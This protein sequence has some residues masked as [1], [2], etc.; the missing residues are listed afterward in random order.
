M[1]A[2]LDDLRRGATDRT[3]R[4][5]ARGGDAP[6]RFRPW[7]LAVVVAAVVLV[8]LVGSAFRNGG[9]QSGGTANVAISTSAASA[10]TTGPVRAGATTA[11]GAASILPAATSASAAFAGAAPAATGTGGGVAAARAAPASGATTDSTGL[12]ASPANL[13]TGE[14]KVI[15][16][17]SI[18]LVVQD[19]PAITNLIWSATTSLGGYVVASSTQGAGDDARGE[20]TLRVPADQYETAMTRL[21]GYGDKVLNEKSTAQD[22]TEEYVD[23]QAR[24]RNLELTVAQLQALLGQAKNVDET[25]RVQS[26]LNAVQGDLERVRGRLKLIDN[27]AAYSTIAVTLTVPPVVKPPTP[28]PPVPVPGW[29]F[30]RSIGEAWGRGLS[31]LQGFADVVI[32]VVFGGWWLIL[33]G[34]AAFVMG[35]RVLRHRAAG[36][37]AVAVAP[38]PPPPPVPPVAPVAG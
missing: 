19:V 30:G 6:R 15:R 17:G 23:L 13:L 21:R 29:S 10:G 32:N 20:I 1:W 5:E 4:T 8:S 18:S 14:A 25:L 22:V 3:V 35:Q 31:G 38:A 34:V 2:R 16:N 33:L 11:A 24:Q 7:W 12:A 36:T 27:R 28:P 37:S 26:Q 9:T